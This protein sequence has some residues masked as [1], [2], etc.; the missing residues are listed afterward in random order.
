MIEIFS[1]ASYISIPWKN[2]KGV[3][4]ELAI[5]DGGSLENFD[6]RLSMAS[7]V[8]DGE[9]SDFSNYW[10]NLILTEGKGIRLTHSNGAEDLLNT[11]LA[12]AS[13]DGGNK[14]TGFLTNGPITDFNVIARKS[15]YQAIVTTNIHPSTTDIQLCPLHFIYSPY[16]T[17]HLKNEHMKIPL[18]LPE[19]HLAKILADEG[20]SITVIGPSF[21]SIG[22]K[23]L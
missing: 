7:V 23:V 18:E 19:K 14:T 8:E 12:L 9:F 10:R 5:N 6:W 3:T 11:P 2:G 21:I 16:E 15:R 4:Q 22:L 17:I 1:P 13:F 20:E